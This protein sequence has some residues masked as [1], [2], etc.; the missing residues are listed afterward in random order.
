MNPS[1]KIFFGYARKSSRQDDRQAL[2]IIDQRAELRALASTYGLTVRHTFEESDSAARTGRL[3]FNDMLRRIEAGEADGLLTWKLDRLARNFDDGGRIIGLLQRGVIKEIRTFEK[4]YLPSDNVLSIALEMGMANQYS[5][6]LATNIRRSIR[7]RLRDGIWPNRAPVGYLNHGPHGAKCIKLDPDKAPLV[8]KAFALY[9][10]GNYTFQEVRARIND[11]GLL[12]CMGKRMSVSNYQSMFKNT[13]YYGVMTFNGQA[14]EGK[15]E[16]IISKRL[17]DEVQ[18]VMLKKSKPKT[19]QLKPYLYRSLFRCGE[20]GCLITTETQKGH[21]YLRCTKRVTACTQRYVREEAVAGQIDRLIGAVSLEAAIADAMLAE[22]GAEQDASVQ[23]EK[24]AIAAAQAALAACDK[25]LDVLLD[26]RLAEELTAAEY[27][28]KRLGLV[29]QKTELKEKI[30]SF[31]A[32]RRDRFEPATRFILEAKYGAK[33]A[34]EG[35]A[36]EKRDF[37]RKVGS[38]L[39]I[40]EKTVG[41]TF[42]NPW[43]C[44]VDWNSSRASARGDNEFSLM[45]KDAEFDRRPNQ[46]EIG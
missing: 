38:N 36:E 6:D 44:V 29:N 13:I 15:H 43:Q 39:K 46:R 32:N 19:P 22:L 40:T 27:A 45:R 34:S 20:C 21:N 10:T 9:A 7:Q 30:A 37:L 4:T 11:A 42:K 3:E 24:A 35:S 26:M 17:F 12:S 23:A 33:L 8:R 28:A 1:P 31:E 14:Y 2:S 18:A 25:Q 16:P 41:V 5:R